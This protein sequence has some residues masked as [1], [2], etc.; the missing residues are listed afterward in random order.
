VQPAELNENGLP[1]T[2]RVTVPVTLE[3][4]AENAYVADAPTFTDP[5]SCSVVAHATG[6]VLKQIKARTT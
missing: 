6:S 2:L 1:V 3:I 4:L 5:K